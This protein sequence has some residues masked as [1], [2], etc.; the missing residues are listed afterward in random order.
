M[1]DGGYGFP[2]WTP[3]V[4]KAIQLPRTD[5]LVF[6]IAAIIIIGIVSIIATRKESK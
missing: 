5:W 4:N 1:F 6:E 3:F 2:I